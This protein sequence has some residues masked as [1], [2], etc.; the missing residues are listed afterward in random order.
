MAVTITDEVLAA[1]IGGLFVIGATAITICMRVVAW[2]TVC[3]D[4]NNTQE[5]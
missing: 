5:E 1:I 3:R 4:P 2:D